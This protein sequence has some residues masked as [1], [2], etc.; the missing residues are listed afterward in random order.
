[1]GARWHSGRAFDSESRG[2]G[3]DP[4]GRHR[5]VSLSKT[6]LLPTVLVKPRKRWLR[7]DMTEKLSTETL[8]LNTKKQ[9]K[10][11]GLYNHRSRLE[12]RYFGFKKK[13]VCT[14][15][16]VTTKTALLSLPMHI[17]VSSPELKAHKVSL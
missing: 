3:F 5:V 17:V 10:Q 12:A 8:S 14:I 9:T 15:C 4:D 11:T 16:V 7:P 1:M 13:T 6:H 2:P